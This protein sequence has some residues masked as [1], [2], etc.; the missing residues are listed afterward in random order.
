MVAERASFS[1]SDRRPLALAVR[2]GGSQCMDLTQRH[3]SIHAR[4]QPEV[5]DRDVARPILQRCKCA[6]PQEIASA[7]ANTGSS[8]AESSAS[9]PSPAAASEARSQLAGRPEKAPD[10]TMSSQRDSC[11]MRRCAIRACLPCGCRWSSLQAAESWTI[12]PWTQE[13]AFGR[14][15]RFKQPCRPQAQ[16]NCE[17]CRVRPE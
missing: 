3:R 7:A 16:D 17:R 9:G 15:R 13:V 8:A 6:R 12:V 5:D 1:G 2:Q 10:V 14:K 4:P 11:S